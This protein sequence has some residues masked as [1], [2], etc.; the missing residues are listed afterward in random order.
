GV[1]SPKIY[2]MDNK[3]L[4]WFAGGE[5]DMK[6]GSGRVNGVRKLDSSQY[7]K[8]MEIS[9]AT[10]C[11]MLIKKNVVETIG[12]FDENYFLYEEDVELSL[13]IT[14]AGYKIVYEPK[15]VVYHRANASIRKSD[16][17]LGILSAKNSNAHIYYYYLV[18]N[19]LFTMR[20]HAN[21]YQWATF[22]PCFF[23]Y[24]IYKAIGAAVAGNYKAMAGIISGI[25]AFI[26]SSKNHESS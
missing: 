20:K 11:A 22:L 25:K 17:F 6:R 24:W 7:D 9:F 21:I 2:F 16:Q 13:R 12:M 8:S 15:A 4:I 5:F 1:V 18:R 23:L 10:G 26:N 14:K 3:H 19:R